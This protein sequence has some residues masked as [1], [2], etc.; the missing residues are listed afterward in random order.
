MMMFVYKYYSVV[1]A[2]GRFNETESDNLKVSSL[3]TYLLI[4]PITIHNW[5]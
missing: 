4:F 3:L 2:H 5:S 1:I